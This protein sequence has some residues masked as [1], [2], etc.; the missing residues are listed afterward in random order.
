MVGPRLLFGQHID[1]R[2]QESIQWYTGVAGR[3]D[4]EKAKDLL[5]SAVADSDAVS[6]MW[7]ARCHSTG[8]MGFRKEVA[9]A[10]ALAAGVIDQIRLLADE[11]VPEAMFL[12]GTAHDEALGVQEDPEKAAEW[13]RK[14]A[15]I[16]HV[17]A[18]HNL[19]NAYFSGRGVR[20]SDSLAVHW[21]LKAADQGDAIPQWR[22]GIMYEEGRGVAMNVEEAERW[23]RRAAKRGETRA[24]EALRRLTAQSN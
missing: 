15:Q 23:Y 21:W 20:Q 9:R 1:D 18:Q 14:A 11:N 2:L 17:L 8:R 3:V 24:K 10:K 4:N 19:G 6:Q 7:L 22:L 5:L 12:M 16:G 13:F